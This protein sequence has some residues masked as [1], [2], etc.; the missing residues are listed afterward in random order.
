MLQASIAKLVIRENLSQAEALAD[1][2]EIMSGKAE[3][4]AVAS[5]LTALSMKGET[6]TK[7]RPA[8]RA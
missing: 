3:P 8:P 7:L 4:A 6:S 1:M 2:R 5:F